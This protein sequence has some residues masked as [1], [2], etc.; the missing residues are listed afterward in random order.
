MI[1]TIIADEHPI[2]FEGLKNIFKKSDIVVTEWAKDG[3]EI[4][5]KIKKTNYDV[6]LLEISLPGR[7]GLE[8]LKQIKKIKP[9]LPVLIFSLLSE[10][11]YGLRA[12][13]AGASGYLSKE[14]SP[15]ELKQ[16][17]YKVYRGNKYVS[18]I[19]SEK[20]AFELDDNAQRNP[21]DKLSDREYQVMCMIASGKSVKQISEELH[22]SVKT[23]STYLSHIKQKMKMSTNSE[24]T[25]YALKQKLVE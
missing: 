16:A 10:E 15:D 3:D 19:L 7:S 23:I 21:H 9:K 22:L 8:V 11:Q 1:K 18:P 2:V 13:R 17:I 6:L 14:A 25:Y 12:L 5:Q 24:I 20:L 4:K